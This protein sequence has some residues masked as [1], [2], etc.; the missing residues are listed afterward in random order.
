MKNLVLIGLPGC[1]KTTVGRRVAAQTG[2]LFADCDEAVEAKWGK[3]IPAI[4]AEEGEEAFRETE[5]QCLAALLR[6]DGHVI[7]AGGGVVVRPENRKLLRGAVVGFLDRKP[8]NIMSTCNLEGRPLMQHATLEELSAQRREWYR[9]CAD[10]IVDKENIE[11]MTE[12]VIACW[13]EA[14]CDF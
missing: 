13:K 14:A 1:G 3:A 12:A 9:A 6:E 10:F 5:S 11:E 7:A 8:E 2:T 4:F